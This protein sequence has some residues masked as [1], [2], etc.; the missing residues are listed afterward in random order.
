MLFIVD[1]PW[2][3][4]L[5]FHESRCRSLIETIGGQRLSQALRREPSRRK[6][7]HDDS[8]DDVSKRRQSTHIPVCCHMIM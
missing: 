4:V 5:Q 3:R 2:G 1:L 6:L 8:G 7:T